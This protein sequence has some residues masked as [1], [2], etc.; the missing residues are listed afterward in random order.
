MSTAPQQPQVP[1]AA[2][3]GAVGENDD[4]ARADDGVPVGAADAEMDAVRSGAGGEDDTVGSRVGAGLPD[5]ATDLD[6]TGD[7]TA[8]DGGVPVGQ[9]DAEADQVRSG[10]D[11]DG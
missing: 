5:T 2:L 3:A 7:A 1:A 9:A 8:T 10:S 6:A 11:D 4:A